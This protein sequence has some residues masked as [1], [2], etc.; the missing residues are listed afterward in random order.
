[1]VRFNPALDELNTAPA[2]KEFDLPVAVQR[3]PGSTAAATRS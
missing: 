1:M 2:G 3:Q